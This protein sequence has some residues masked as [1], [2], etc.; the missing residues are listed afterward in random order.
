MALF[1]HH[2]LRALQRILCLVVFFPSPALWVL[3]LS[4]Y[5]ERPLAYL[6]LRRFHPSLKV[7]EEVSGKH[8]PEIVTFLEE[9]QDVFPEDLP[10]GLPP[11]SSV[12]IQPLLSTGVSKLTAYW[13]S[14]HDP[15]SAPDDDEKNCKMSGT[16][17]DS[18]ISKIRRAAVTALS[19]AAVNAKL[20]ANQ[21]EVQIRQ[22]VSLVIE[23]QLQKLEVKLALFNDIETV[24]MRLR[25]QLERARQRLM[26]ERAQII[27]ARL[28][29]PASSSRSLPPTMP[30]AR[31]AMS[32]DIKAFKADADFSGT[33]QRQT[34]YQ[35]LN[36]ELQLDVVTFKVRWSACPL[37]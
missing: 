23:K 15:K 35:N 28:G 21:E 22:L 8:P 12:H 17:D 34:L 16:K 31:F 9:F 30:A 29:L 2:L 4:P 24:I 27:A 32:H 33:L 25:E 26:H 6:P 7:V 10:D 11:Q 37:G 13:T 36:S 3:L 14:E 5:L 20:L 1:L 19:A 18:T